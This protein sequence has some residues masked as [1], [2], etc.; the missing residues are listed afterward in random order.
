MVLGAPSLLR[1]EC[2]RAGAFALPFRCRA[3]ARTTTIVRWWADS[4]GAPRPRPCPAA[5]RPKPARFYDEPS[6]RTR[7]AR[8]APVGSAKHD[9]LPR[10]LF[11]RSV[12]R[13][14]TEHHDARAILLSERDRTVG[15]MCGR[16]LLRRGRSDLDRRR[17]SRGERYGTPPTILHESNSSVRP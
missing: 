1:A 16:L 13:T 14:R 5:K 6:R 17:N 7:A 10:L 11:S 15:Q 4:R 12:T 8:P 2:A 9:A 3:G